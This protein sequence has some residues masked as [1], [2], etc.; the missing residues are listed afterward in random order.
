MLI[1][2]RTARLDVPTRRIHSTPTPRSAWLFSILFVAALVLLIALTWQSIHSARS[3]V[4]IAR[5]VISDYTSIVG[6]EF[7]RPMRQYF[8]YWWSYQVGQLLVP[9]LENHPELGIDEL[10][11]PER[12]PVSMRQSIP[13]IA[14]IFRLETDPVRVEWLDGEAVVADAGIAAM[15]PAAADQE[16]LSI[17][18]P[19]A[20]DGSATM[21]ALYPVPGK[22]YLYGATF[23]ADAIEDG[24]QRLFD[25]YRLFPSGILEKIEGNEGIYLRVFTPSGELAFES[26]MSAELAQTDQRIVKQHTIGGDYY[27]LFDGY[28]IVTELDPSLAERLV[29]GGLPQSRLPILI[30]L[31]LLTMG[32]LGAIIW[33]LNKERALAAM[34]AEFVS[35]VSHELR[36]P[37]TQI[38]LS[39][40]TMLLGRS[41]D[42]IDAERQ[43][44]IINREAK[45]LGH[46]VSN[47]LTLTGRDRAPFIAEI[48]EQRVC[49][50]LAQII[51]DYRSM[52]AHSETRIELIGCEGPAGEIRAALDREAFTQVILN[53]LDNACKYGPPGQRVRVL[54]K[55]EEDNCTIAV[56][57]QGPGVPASEKARV[58]GL[59]ERLERD[60]NRAVNGTGIGLPIAR[61]LTEAMGGRCWVEDAPSGGA[62]FVVQLR[63]VCR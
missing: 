44:R 16:G 13:A 11:I 42:S 43:L 27:G 29:I 35:R 61:E 30:T 57:D 40:E 34:R 60:E 15:L 8:G 4:E 10:E 59:Y 47:V 31:L 50:R 41:R 25:S 54:F 62:R 38:R 51:S 24:L 6:G 3:N 1:V 9:Q 2:F 22:R 20:R 37:L 48:H 45:R 5:A 49:A 39:A 32:V 26:E 18:H 58:F 7:E 28:T 14:G 63:R 46:M 23:A 55:A 12:A 19:P 56:E 52:L 36:T 53:L 21:T 33:V 17:H